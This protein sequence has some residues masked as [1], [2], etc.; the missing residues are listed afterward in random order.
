M[1]FFDTISTLGNTLL[2]AA[3]EAA[4]AVKE[5][6]AHGDHLELIL[7]LTSGLAA[8]LLMGYITQRLG[9]SPIVGYLL[10]GILVGPYT[11]GLEADVDLAQQ[12][13][14]IGV[15]LLM[16]GVGLHFH[17]KELL[18]VRRVAVPGAVGQSLFATLLGMLV[19]WLLGWDLSAGIVFGLAISVA[20][21]V[22]LLRVL[23]DNNDL[24]TPTGHI[25]V[26]WLVVEDLF[27]VLVLVLMPVLF[28]AKESSLATI[29]WALAI[30]I[31]KI[32]LLVAFVMYVGGQ[33]IPWFLARIAR[34]RSRELFTL[35]VLVVALGIAVGAARVFDVSMALGAFLAGMVVGRSE[36]SSRAASE[37]LPMRDA[38]AVLFFVSVGMLFNPQYLLDAPVLIA[39]ALGIV[40]IGKPLAALVIVLVLRY[41]L[42]VAL[43]VAVALA[44]IGE[45]S[46]ILANVG[47]GLKVFSDLQFNALIAAA[48]VSISI[49]PILYRLVD[50]LE[51]RAKQTPWMWSILNGRSKVSLDTPPDEE[52]DDDREDHGAAVVVGYGPVGRTLVRLL[53]E[54]GIAP[55]IIELNLETVRA[56]RAEGIGAV[57]GDSSHRETQLEA[58][59]KKA[60]V[61]IL[62]AS[63]LKNS[64]EVIR[65]ARECNPAI[66]VFARAAYL[67]EIPSLTKA[68][69]DVVFTGEGEVAMT[70]TEFILR[71]LGASGEQIDRE[72]DRIRSELFGSPAALEILLPPT[73]R[74]AI[75][76]PAGNEQQT[77]PAAEPPPEPKLEQT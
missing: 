56:L 51:N 14:E 12:M 74:H 40:L 69:A 58:G 71:Q 1:P 27:T 11:P 16:F 42:R 18:A 43:S 19:G 77:V 25:A 50:W 44:Q 59:M 34:T 48:I 38:F 49:N 60:R 62:S 37:A 20:S 33:V 76:T 46:F 5:A 67:R 63:G 53:Q 52:E 17:F 13:A 64:Q 30:A 66:R 75:E 70:M 3:A 47:M 21:T 61:L 23:S 6:A 39:A 22:V 4:P 73:P 41:P 26:G 10:A 24:H 45:F 32:G 68:G 54:N 36:F 2:L 35:T 72:R 65:V 9:L 55:T 7:T 57:Y 8:A 29:G 28:G 15:I 31:A